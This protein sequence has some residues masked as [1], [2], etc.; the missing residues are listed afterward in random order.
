[1]QFIMD[2]ALVFAGKSN[3]KTNKNEPMVDNSM[4]AVH[5]VHP[6]LRTFMICFL[7]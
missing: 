6:K 1:V 2:S 3:V 5:F 4:F 7:T